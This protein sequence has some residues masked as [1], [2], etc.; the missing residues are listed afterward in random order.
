MIEFLGDL[1][2][3]SGIMPKDPSER[4][5]IRAFVAL[6]EDT[7]VRRFYDAFYRGE[8]ALPLL[9]ALEQLQ[10]R[11]PVEGFAGGR[12]SMAEMALA[13]FIVWAWMMW[14]RDIGKYP[15]GQGKQIVETLRRDLEYERIVSYVEDIKAYP[16]FSATWDEVSQVSLVKNL[17]TP[18]WIGTRKSSYR[19]G[20][21]GLLSREGHSCTSTRLARSSGNTSM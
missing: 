9:D 11:L 1:F 6:S 13:P 3:D 15:E 10:A 16:T 7:F 8:S 18:S 5:K 2:P 4:A 17:T 12:W 19:R 14:E 21:F 20:E